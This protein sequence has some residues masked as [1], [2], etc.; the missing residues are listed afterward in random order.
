MSIQANVT[1]LLSKLKYKVGPRARRLKNV[2]GP[3]GRIKK[4]QKTLTALLKH[5]RIEL[6]YNRA[7]ETRGYVELVRLLLLLNNNNKYS[8][9]FFYFITVFKYYSLIRYPRSNMSYPTKFEK[10]TFF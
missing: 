8:L 2:E 9:L 10:L 6:Y 7:D 5:E 3:A 1:H 4:I